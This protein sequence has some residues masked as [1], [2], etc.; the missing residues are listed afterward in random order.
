MIRNV[1]YC[2]LLTSCRHFKLQR[3]LISSSHLSISNRTRLSTFNS[4]TKLRTG[5]AVPIYKFDNFS[6]TSNPPTTLSKRLKRFGISFFIVDCC[7][8]V[9][10]IATFFIL[11]SA[12]LEMNT[13]MFYAEQ[14]MDV[15]YWTSWYGINPESLTGD[16]AAVSLAWVVTAATSPIRLLLDLTI[17]VTLKKLRVIGE[18]KCT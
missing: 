7:T 8:W 5:N 18:P 12:G 3:A 10:S 4:A 11:F 6:T 2:T 17:L 13:L 16:G 9:G 1:P 14:M 15:A